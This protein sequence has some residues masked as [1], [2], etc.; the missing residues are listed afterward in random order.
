[1]K[2]CESPVMETET[3][4]NA[5]MRKSRRRWSFWLLASLLVICVI[6]SCLVKGRHVATGD[7]VSRTMMI[8]PSHVTASEPSHEEIEKRRRQNKI[9]LERE[10]LNLKIE[11]AVGEAEGRT[12]A[13]KRKIY[14]ICER[15]SGKMPLADAERCFR[16]S[17]DGVRFLASRE[18][19]CGFKSLA[20]LAWKMAYDKCKGT[21]RA[22]EA[23]QPLVQSNVVEHVEG[24]VHIYNRWLDDFRKDIIAEER[25]FAIDLAARGAKFRNEVSILSIEEASSADLSVKQFVDDMREL[26]TKSAFTAFGTAVELAMI[27]SS[28][29]AIKTI[30]KAI[31][32]RSLSG[33]VCRMTASVGTGVGAAAADGPLPVGDVIGAVVIVGT[34]IW[35]AYDIYKV[36]E[37]MPDEM[38][39]KM[40]KSIAEIRGSLLENGRRQVE[41]D[42]KVCLDSMDE[43]LAKFR[44]CLKPKEK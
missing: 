34:T 19:L 17:E 38:R 12:R 15:Y 44:K 22:E 35:A 26:A 13:F 23:L 7:S 40:L 3:K 6:A 18:G 10:M 5:I 24:A 39:S 20:V 16:N 36:T 33:V 8:S 4:D 41:E 37:S 30:V 14:D 29:G 42:R 25:A 31:A 11:K 21:Q 1:M 27:K 2:T 43:K 9:D 32:T 28:W